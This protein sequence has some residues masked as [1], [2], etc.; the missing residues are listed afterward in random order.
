MH[1]DFATRAPARAVDYL[2]AARIHHTQG[3]IARQ[4]GVTVRTVRRWEARE[5]EPPPYVVHALQR[6]LPFQMPLRQGGEFTFID[7]FAGIGGLR[8][9][10]EEIGGK[11]VFTSEWDAY[12]NRTYAENF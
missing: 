1:T 2:T 5:T 4:L 3:S 8:L 10:F 12:A 6:L 9:P 11:C 7:L